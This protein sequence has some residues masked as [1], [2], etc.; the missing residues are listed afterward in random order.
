LQALP[1][2]AQ[3]D[4]QAVFRLQPTPADVSLATDGER[5]Y[6]LSGAVLTRIER[7]CAGV[8]QAQTMGQD[9]ITTWHWYEW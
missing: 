3:N 5:L 4:S 7:N 6:Y 1:F 2:C 8:H 9:I